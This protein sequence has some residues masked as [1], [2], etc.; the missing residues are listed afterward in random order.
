MPPI[1]TQCWESPWIV[2]AEFLAGAV[3]AGHA[4][5][6]VAAFLADYPVIWPDEDG[7]LHYA[8]LYARL[9][10]PGAHVGPNV[11]WIGVA[12]VARGVPLLTRNVAE[13]SRIEG[14]QIVDYAARKNTGP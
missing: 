13:L 7:L 11:L 12:A 3:V 9:R 2:K 5:P 1:P 14:L 10:Q 4:L 8:R 6:R